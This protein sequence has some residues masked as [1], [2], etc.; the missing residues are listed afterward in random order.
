VGPGGEKAVASTYPRSLVSILLLLL[1]LPLPFVAKSASAFTFVSVWL[2][3][4]FALSG[5]G[6]N[7]Q[8][9]SARHVLGGP[10]FLRARTDP[11]LMVGG[12]VV[13][14]AAPGRPRLRCVVCTALPT[15][16]IQL[17]AQ[18][19]SHAPPNE[20]NEKKKPTSEPFAAQGKKK[21]F[22]ADNGRKNRIGL[23]SVQFDLCKLRE[24]S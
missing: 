10:P 24:S 19:W 12:V 11:K 14:G 13:G 4:A 22:K 9:R 3:W 15:H 20:R 7:L 2:G 21:E 8:Q 1:L 16:Q 5:L 23:E 6:F 18:N 17:A